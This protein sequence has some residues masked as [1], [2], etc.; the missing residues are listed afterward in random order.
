MKRLVVFIFIT[1]L[2]IL[3]SC[4][5]NEKRI[6]L[7]PDGTTVEQKPIDEKNF[8]RDSGGYYRTDSNTSATNT[9]NGWRP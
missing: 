5:T 8:F 2:I 6:A 7:Y 3:T 9:K 1:Y 4:A